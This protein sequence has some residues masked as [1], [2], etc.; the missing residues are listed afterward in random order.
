MRNLFLMLV[1]ANLA[2]AAWEYGRP[3]ATGDAG[4]RAPGASRITLVSELPERSAASDRAGAGAA[5]GRSSGTPA[6]PAPADAAEGGSGD[7]NAAEAGAD[8]GESSDRGTET[9]A[10][11]ADENG[12]DA[13]TDP[14][15]RVCRS[16]GPFEALS[17][18][19]AAAAALRAEGLEPKQRVA[20]GDIW[21]G[22]WVYL[23][24][25]PAD[26]Q[27]AAV[28]A[29][30]EDAGIPEAYLISGSEPGGDVISLGVFTETARAERLAEQVRGLGYEP[31]IADRTRRGTVYWVDASLEPGR[32]LD[33][34]QLQPPGRIVRLEQRPCP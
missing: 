4:A 28:L 26:Q 15:E 31:T 6:E 7:G 33:L 1:L 9:D 16:V 21:V 27:A 19:T 24:G 29:E 17:Q 25:L 8:A 5:S 14:S 13:A 3:D 20:E 23:D 18:A 10:A 32:T 11:A 2:F 22:Y 12:T 30:L 34:E